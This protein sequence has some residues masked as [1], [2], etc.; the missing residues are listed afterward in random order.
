MDV[1]SSTYRGVL[2]K[3]WPGSSESIIIVGS[4]IAKGSNRSAADAEET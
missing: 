2:A 1:V 3:W 4:H